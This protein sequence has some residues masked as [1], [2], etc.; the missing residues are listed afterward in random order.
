[1]LRFARL[2]LPTLLAI[3]ASAVPASAQTPPGDVVISEFRTRGPAGGNDEFVELRNRS[4]GPVEISGWRLQGCA[5]GTGAASNRATVDSDVFLPAGG[6][7]LFANS[8]AAGYSGAVEPDQ[9]YNTGFT[10]FLNSNASGIQIVD[11]ATVRDG[12]GSP[13]SPCR[14]GTGITTPTNPPNPN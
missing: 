4:A 10:D 11:A 8:G 14:E 3:L 12:V 1:M 6:S 7:Y 2:A 5:A 9:T 13:S